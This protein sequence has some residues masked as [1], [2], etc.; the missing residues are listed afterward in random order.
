MKNEWHA[1]VA[2]VHIRELPF[3]QGEGDLGE[4]YKLQV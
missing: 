2:Y 3:R 1:V 4:G